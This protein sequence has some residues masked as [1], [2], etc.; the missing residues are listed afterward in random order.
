VTCVTPRNG[1]SSQ[2]DGAK[3]GQGHMTEPQTQLRVRNDPFWPAAII[4]FALSITVSWVILL[5][6]AL[7]KLVRLA[8]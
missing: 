7:V 3:E 8:L 1:Q 2:I 4:T 5:G 6:Y